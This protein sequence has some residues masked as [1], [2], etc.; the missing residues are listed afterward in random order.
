MT[1]TGILLAAGRGERLRPLTDLLPKPALPLLDVPLGAWGLCNLAEA[2]DEV[3]VN[4]SHLA[5]HVVGAL[6]SFGAFDV[7]DEGPVP[8]GSAATLAA[9]AGRSGETVVVVNSDVVSGV[10]ATALL[11]AHRR[12]GRMATVAVKK[13]ASGA[14]FTTE[15]SRATAFIDRRARPAGSGVAYLGLAAFESSALE[16]LPRRRPAGLAEFLLRPL[17]EKGELQVHPVDGY[18]LDVGTTGRFLTAS[19]DL[20]EG[21]APPPP[22]P[23]PG[24]LVELAGGRAYL[25]PEATADEES[26]G[27]GAVVLAGA[28][29]HQG[30]YV[31]DAVVWP[32]SE[33]P[34]DARIERGVWAKGRL[35]T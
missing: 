19:A 13:V 29:L 32:D 24:E 12:S 16:L 17:V 6:A 7:L 20:L 1:V 18:A 3:V 35:H 25:G 5:D 34:S 30:S 8:W 4:V 33:V 31:S 22:A 28:V 23:V 21:R 10:S 11:A 2:T 14:D 27:P 26:L 9:V 15:G